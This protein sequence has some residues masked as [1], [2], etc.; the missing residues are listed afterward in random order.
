MGV[1]EFSLTFFYA[2]GINWM[3]KRPLS[4]TIIGWTFIAVGI[5]GLI[6]HS[7]H[8]KE[9]YIVWIL[10]LRLLALVCGVCMLFRQNWARWLTAAWLVYHVYLSVHH[11]TSELIIHALLFVVIVFFLFRRAATAYFRSAS[12]HSL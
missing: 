2:S 7:T 3:H 11:K 1:R 8:P 10:F 6:Y 5:V 9:D 4:I 12:S